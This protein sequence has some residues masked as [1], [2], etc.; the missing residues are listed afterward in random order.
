MVAP[1]V[2]CNCHA[3]LRRIN[4]VF[5]MKRLA[6]LIVATTRVRRRMIFLAFFESGDGEKSAPDRGEIAA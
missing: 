2:S 4:A 5:Q 1:L 3:M 6:F